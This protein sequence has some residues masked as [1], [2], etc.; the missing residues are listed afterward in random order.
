MKKIS[1]VDDLQARNVS[2]GLIQFSGKLEIF[3][4]QFQ[5]LFLKLFL[6]PCQFS[7]LK[8]LILAKE[9]FTL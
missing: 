2:V 6:G 1:Q 4:R 3:I 5:D 7:V 9:L 8:A